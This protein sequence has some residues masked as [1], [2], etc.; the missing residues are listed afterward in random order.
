MYQKLKINPDLL[1]IFALITMTIDHIGMILLSDKDSVFRLIGR[2]AFPVFAF[3]LMY[4]LYQK[5]IFKK[6]M[7]RLLGF[8][9]L[10]TILLMPFWSG[11]LN[12]MW[13][14]LL[15]VLTL[16]II[17]KAI[18]DMPWYLAFCVGLFVWLVLGVLSFST[19]Y[20]LGGYLYLLSFWIYF[21]WPRLVPVMLLFVLAFLLNQPMIVGG[22]ITV[23]TTGFLLCVDR[24][25]KYPRLIKNKWFFYFYYPLHLL[26]LY[27]IS[28][29]IKF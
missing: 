12:V 29:L 18:E 4:H 21:K 13:T 28:T 5:K 6:Y 26:F 17:E 20:S 15:P 22:V 23:L 7:L 1:K 3:L 24:D 10:T 27:A 11:S 25:E 8:G 2:T 14:F 16:W 19:N 9:L